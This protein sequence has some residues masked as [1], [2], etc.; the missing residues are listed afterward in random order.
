MHNN[1]L[2]IIPNIIIEFC[3]KGILNNKLTT[4]FNISTAINQTTRTYKI[5]THFN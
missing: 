3:I 2:C 5:T 4:P 1:S